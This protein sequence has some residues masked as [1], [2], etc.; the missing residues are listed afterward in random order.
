MTASPAGHTTRVLSDDLRPLVELLA[1]LDAVGTMDLIVG[2]NPIL[3]HEPPGP[4]SLSVVD[5]LV[6]QSRDPISDDVIETYPVV[7]EGVKEG[8]AQGGGSGGLRGS[9]T[10][11]ETVVDGRS[12]RPSGGAAVLVGVVERRR[13]TAAGR[14]R[15]GWQRRRRRRTGRDRRRRREQSSGGGGGG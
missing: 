14:R 15:G 2:E 10:V 5:P 11:G 4:P 9:G 3:E 8:G 6:K 7:V 1:D 13:V 12:R